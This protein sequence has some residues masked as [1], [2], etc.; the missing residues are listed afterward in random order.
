MESQFATLAPDGRTVFWYQSKG[1]VRTYQEAQKTAE[2]KRKKEEKALPLFAPIIDQVS[3][4]L[5]TPE[6]IIEEGLHEWDKLAAHELESYERAQA[7]RTIVAEL[8]TPDELAAMDDY[9]FRVFPHQVEYS[10]S[11]WFSRIK[12]LAPERA[13]KL[14]LNREQHTTMSHSYEK[15]PAC[16]MPLKQEE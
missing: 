11:F 3:T 7:L 12:E 8:V 16:G 10:Y 6:Q 13:H 14:C 9:R 2:R 15:C 5:K 1:R 4:R